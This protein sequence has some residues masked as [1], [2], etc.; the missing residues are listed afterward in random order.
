MTRAEDL[1]G[2]AYEL[3]VERSSHCVVFP[4]YTEPFVARILQSAAEILGPLHGHHR[5]LTTWPERVF[6]TTNGVERSVDS[7]WKREPMWLRSVVASTR[8]MGWKPLGALYELTRLDGYK[9]LESDCRWEALPDAL[10]QL[11]ADS[12]A[13]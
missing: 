6:I 7:M 11:T 3:R 9:T 8:A 2:F 12:A 1:A 4:E 13:A 10:P 5:G